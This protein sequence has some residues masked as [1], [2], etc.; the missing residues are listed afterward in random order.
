MKTLDLTNATISDEALEQIGMTMWR[1]DN[2]K[3]VDTEYITEKG[4]I[5]FCEA[6]KKIGAVH[7]EYFEISYSYL[8]QQFFSITAF[9][10]IF[11][12]LHIVSIVLHLDIFSSFLSDPTIM[13]LP[14]NVWLLLGHYPH[15]PIVQSIDFSCNKCFNIINNQLHD[16]VIITSLDNIP[17]YFPHAMKVS[18]SGIMMTPTLIDRMYNNFKKTTTADKRRK[19][20]YKIEGHVLPSVLPPI[21]QD[22]INEQKKDWYKAK[23]EFEE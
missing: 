12:T 16:E 10:S 17:W 23:I 9:E 11:Q 14:W 21:Y 18:V 15:S 6:R 2:I 19:R 8:Q 22:S 7:F 3:F 1:L 13:Q 20:E 4:M 5:A